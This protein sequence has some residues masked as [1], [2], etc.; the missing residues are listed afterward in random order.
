MGLGTS[1]SSLSVSIG[2]LSSP[3]LGTFSILPSPL[4]S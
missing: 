4:E 1:A 2:S 3:Q